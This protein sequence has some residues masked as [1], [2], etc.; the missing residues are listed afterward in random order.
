MTSR[1]DILSALNSVQKL[2]QTH[3]EVFE[4]I[5]SIVKEYDVIDRE[6]LCSKLTDVLAK[7]GNKT[8]INF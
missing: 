4:I 1:T 5:E 7:L 6:D 2:E 8:T 3:N